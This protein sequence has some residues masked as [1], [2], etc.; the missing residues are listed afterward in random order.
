MKTLVLKLYGPMQSWG[1]N[2]RFTTRHTRNEP[3][4][5]GVLGLLA[6]AQGRRRSDP[7]EDLAELRFGVRVDQPGELVRD[8]QTAIDWRSGR[9]MPLSTRYYL[10]DAVFVA[11]VEGPEPL[12]DSLEDALESPGF[13][14]YL[15]RRSCP[16]NSDL[17]LGTSHRSLDEA[18]RET[19]WQARPWHRHQRPKTVHL[20]VFR[21][22]VQEERGDAQRDV[23]VSFDQTH[24]KYSWREVVTAEPVTQKNPAG[25]NH[26]DA[27]FEA[28]NSG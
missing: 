13:P 6:A 8:F 25:G 11:A 15:G 28:V 23:P 21:D 17:V 2:S 12:I 24:R 1:D 19:P 22:A 10:A 14:L 18:L 26:I 7:L 20:P 5:S 3:T 4:K 27:F 16:A 9:S